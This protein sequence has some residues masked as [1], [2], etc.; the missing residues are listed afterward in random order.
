MF[1]FTATYTH[2][3]IY[4]HLNIKTF[5]TS[6]WALTYISWLYLFEQEKYFNFGLSLKLEWFWAKDS[7]RVTTSSDPRRILNW[8][9]ISREDKKQILNMHFLNLLHSILTHSYTY[10]IIFCVVS[11]AEYNHT[12]SVLFCLMIL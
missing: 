3:Y 7:L 1:F 11:L 8:P 4:K 2:W 12:T 6:F 5:E 10:T 9:T